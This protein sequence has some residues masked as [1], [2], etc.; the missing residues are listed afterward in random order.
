MK[1]WL[2]AH[3]GAWLSFMAIA[4]LVTGG[5]AWATFMALELENEQRKT[6]AVQERNQ[7]LRLAL[8]RLDSRV[9]PVLAREANR[10]FNHYRALYANHQSL[11]RQGKT[12]RTGETLQPS[13]LLDE[14]LPTWVLLHFQV[15]PLAVPTIWESPQ[16]LNEVDRAS[17]LAN[18]VLT[19]CEN[20]TDERKALF[21]SLQQRLDHQFFKQWLQQ[22]IPLLAFEPVQQTA[23]DELPPSQVATG[24]EPPP[25]QQLIVPL[26][27]QGGASGQKGGFVDQEF[28]SRYMQKAQIEQS[29][30]NR[31]NFNQ[32]P[33]DVQR[34]ESLSVRTG[35]IQPIWLADSQNKEQESLL[36]AR[37]VQMGDDY[38]CQGFVLDWKALSQELAESV[39]DLFPH[40]TLTAMRQAV[41]DHPEQSMTAL[42]LALEPNEPLTIPDM[43]SW[44]PLCIGLS[45]AWMAATIA[46]L[47]VAFGGWS[48][49]DLSDRRIRFISTVTHELRTPLTTLRLY[50]DMLTSG[51][52]E[53]E[54]KKNEYLKTL[55]QEA[56]RLHRLISNVLDY[57][58][59]ENRSTKLDRK[60]ASL[61]SLIE[62]VQSAWKDRCEQTGKKLVVQAE[63]SLAGVILQTDPVLVEQILGNL[64]DNAC[65]YSQ[66]AGDDRI[67]LRV[68]QDAQ[69]VHMAV[70]DHGP[71]VPTS[72]RQA[73]FRPFQRGQ[74]IHVTSEG[75]GLGLALARRWAQLLGGS[76]SLEPS[77]NGAGACFQLTLPK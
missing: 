60:P 18:P 4:L 74:S 15:S 31:N 3:W 19:N 2:R 46:L 9:F 36:M 38:F 41:P 43:E 68:K 53:D 33:N 47:A 23:M 29:P 13:P 45:L 39:H 26:P 75:V 12:W 70:E 8:W 67:V 11:I 17:L 30:S 59:L 51:L 50:S 10:P 40:A 65:K 69:N 37:L 21:L 16:V 22:Q 6:R 49:I 72:E 76:L 71:G 14:P 32:M 66:K 55:H 5:L 25:Q 62:Q 63:P 44:S 27:R 54:T 35:V 24:S 64:I 20:V 77:Q 7:K 58:R 56:E 1:R 28:Q 48:L 52:I 42:P 34:K 61:K 73:I 57:S